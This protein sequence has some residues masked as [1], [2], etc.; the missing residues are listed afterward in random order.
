MD[1]SSEKPMQNINREGVAK[2]IQDQYLLHEVVH[3]LPYESA[4][5]APAVVSTKAHRMADVYK[6]YHRLNH[7]SYVVVDLAVLEN[8]PLSWLQI[9]L[10]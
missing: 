9:A 1:V 8:S 6:A 7:P 4:D 2:I 3:H 5:K 10:V